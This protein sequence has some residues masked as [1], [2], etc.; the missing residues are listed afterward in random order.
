MAYVVSSQRTSC[1]WY[2]V[3]VFTSALWSNA[4]TVDRGWEERSMKRLPFVLRMKIVVAYVACVPIKMRSF[5][6]LC[7]FCELPSMCRCK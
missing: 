4:A 7:I 1:A 3:H 6:H 5:E 2:A